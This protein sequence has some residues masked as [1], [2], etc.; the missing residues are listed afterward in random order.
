ME[1]EDIL[2]WFYLSKCAVDQ[3]DVVDEA[4]NI[5]TLIIDSNKVTSFTP[6][7]VEYI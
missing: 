4:I 3:R 6:G 1:I 2:G 7:K 5:L